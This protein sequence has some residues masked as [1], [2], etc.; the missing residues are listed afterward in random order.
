[1]RRENMASSFRS[2][3]SGGFEHYLS[4]ARA[5]PQPPETSTSGFRA[6]DIKHSVKMV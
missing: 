2:K 5:L 4:R 1:M 6:G 3:A